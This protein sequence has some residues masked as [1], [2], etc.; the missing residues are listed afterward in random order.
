M[1]AGA[2]RA[3]MTLRLGVAV[4]LVLAGVACQ[5]AARPGTVV[6]TPGALAVEVLTQDLAV[7]DSRLAM[8]VLADGRPLSQG[9]VHLVFY[10]LQDPQPVVRAE[11]DAVTRLDQ[12]EHA[13]LADHVDLPF[14]VAP[15]RFDRAGPWGVEVQVNK[16]GSTTGVARTRL[17]VREQPI[18]P[19]IGSPAPRSASKTL[20]TAPPEELSSAMPIDPELYRLSVAEA[21]DTGRPLVL[22]FA[23]PAFCQSRTCGPQLHVIEHLKERYGEQVNFIHV[24][25]YDKPQEAAR[26]F[27]SARPS[28]TVTEWRLPSEPWV[29]VVD[30]QGRIAARFEGFVTVEELEPELR[31]VLARL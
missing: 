24:E 14:Y 17:D 26:D 22:A 30:A 15:V 20:R 11:A 29:F 3:W 31:Q 7:G 5:S 21:I 4:A 19:A 27:R 23:T 8:V 9:Q 2:K 10:Y 13:N 6:P 25:V 28:S 16:P 12:H 18:A 1:S